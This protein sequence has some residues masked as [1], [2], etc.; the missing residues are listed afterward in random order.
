M[1]TSK[2]AKLSAIFRALPDIYFILTPE[3]SIDECLSANAADLY[4][5]QEFFIGKN[6]KEVVPPHVSDLVIRLISQARKSKSLEIGEYPLMIGDQNK[7]FEIRITSMPAE[8]F[9]CIIRN[10][11]EKK[12]IEHQLLLTMRM[13]NLSSLAAGI[14]HDLNN[15]LTPAMLSL[16]LLES[17]I[18]DPEGIRLL[19]GAERVIKRSSEF[20]SQLMAYSANKKVTFGNVDLEEILKETKRIVDLIFPKGIEVT[21]EIEN[22]LGFLYGSETQLEQV[23]MNLCIN[24]RDAL[25]GKGKIF[26]SAKKLSSEIVCI[27][28]S[29]NGPGIPESVQEHILEPFFTTKEAGKGSGVGLAFV[30]AVVKS[31]RGIISFTSG[32]EHGT[33]FELRFPLQEPSM[34]GAVFQNSEKKG[35]LQGSTILVVDDDPTILSLIKAVLEEKDCRVEVAANGK[36]AMEI[37]KRNNHTFNLVVSDVIM[38]ALDGSTLVR[39]IKEINPS[40]KMLLISGYFENET[41]LALRNSGVKTILHKPFSMKEFSD[42]VLK[43]IET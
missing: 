24:A 5:P 43:E 31:H 11:T 19:S 34:E 26:I 36:K 1:S 32:Q 28:V 35:N 9:I 15:L 29:D 4:M 42:A 30:S 7:Y 10:I 27:T 12:M 22:K 40:Q 41:E 16:S 2:E 23:V 3:G 17:H 39:L 38:P 33:T 20:I 25:K 18:S 37:Y 8:K 6:V 21:W 14:A 13:T